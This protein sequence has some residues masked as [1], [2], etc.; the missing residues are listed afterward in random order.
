MVGAFKAIEQEVLQKAPPPEIVFMGSSRMRDAVEPRA[1]EALLGLPRGGVLNLGLTGGMPYEAHRFYSDHR[2]LLR[3]ARVLV[4]GV[5][6]WYWNDGTA[7]DQVERHFATMA[8]RWQWFGEQRKLGDLV[9]GVW[10]TVELQEPLVRFATSYVKG[11]KAVQFHEDRVAWR[12]ASDVREV[13]PEQTDVAAAIEQSMQGFALGTIHEPPL[14]ELVSKARADGLAVILTRLPLRRSYCDELDRR[15]PTIVPFMRERLD[16]IVS[17]PGV[18]LVMYDAGDVL[19][20]PE[21]RFYDYGHFT[22]DG[23]RRMNRVWAKLLAR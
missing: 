13:G 8:D 19:G 9:G 14:R 12:A 1:L 16:R 22:V 2:S 15:Y 4:V 23:V 11:V 17:E 6:D 10:K 20:I 5:E 21:D 3:S 18:Q 7:R